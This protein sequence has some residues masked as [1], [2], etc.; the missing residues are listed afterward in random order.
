MAC[1]LIS[2]VVLAS[3][4]TFFAGLKICP[5]VFS[6]LVATGEMDLERVS[7]TWGVIATGSNIVM[8]W[9][10]IFTMVELK[11]KGI[12]SLWTLAMSAIVRDGIVSLSMHVSIEAKFSMG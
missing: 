10:Q 7:V 2:L 4:L 9:P 3:L 11:D 5:Y 1:G 8:W 6:C 12:L